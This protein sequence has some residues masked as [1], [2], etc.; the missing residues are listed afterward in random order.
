MLGTNKTKILLIILNTVLGNKTL[1]VTL[2]NFLVSFLETKGDI[3]T[4]S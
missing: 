2:K 4:L 1:Q 3:H